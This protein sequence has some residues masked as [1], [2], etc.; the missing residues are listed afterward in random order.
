M[1]IAVSI[2]CRASEVLILHIEAT[3]HTTHHT[4][5]AWDKN[6]RSPG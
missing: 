3:P 5:G 2:M 1:I 4:Q 6:V